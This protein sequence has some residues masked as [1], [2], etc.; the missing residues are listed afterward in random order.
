MPLGR[1]RN[2]AKSTTKLQLDK[3]RRNTEDVW[4][5]LTAEEGKLLKDTEERLEVIEGGELTSL[6]CGRVLGDLNLRLSDA[7]GNTSKLKFVP[8]WPCSGPKQELKLVKTHPVLLEE[9]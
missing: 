2:L 6:N 3:P 5:G 9:P 1:P 4:L 8:A 7:R